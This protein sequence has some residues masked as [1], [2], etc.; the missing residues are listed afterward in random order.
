MALAKEKKGNIIKEFQLHP[1]DK[2]SQE[3]QI[4]ILTQRVNDLTEHLK[5]NPK[6]FHS[7]LGLLKMVGQRKRLL[8]YL[9]R[10]N[11]DSYKKIIEKLNLRK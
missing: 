7:R 6:D 3:I 10:K 9:K 8:A 2:G 4:A 5:T 11:P 1:Q